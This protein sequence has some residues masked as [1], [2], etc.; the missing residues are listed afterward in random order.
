MI[1][2]RSAGWN[3]DLAHWSCPLSHETSVRCRLCAW[4]VLVKPGTFAHLV[5]GIAVS[6]CG[7]L[8]LSVTYV[9]KMGLEKFGSSPE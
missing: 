6:M 1:S 9:C 3:V 8:P 5:G 7:S 2:Q 4:G